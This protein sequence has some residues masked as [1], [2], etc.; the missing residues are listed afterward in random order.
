MSKAK[1]I[2]TVSLHAGN[3]GADGAHEL[4]DTIRCG[5]SGVLP[6]EG[7]SETHLTIGVRNAPAGTQI[8]HAGFWKE[9]RDVDT[10]E[11]ESQ[12]F[13]GSAPLDLSVSG[14]EDVRL[15]ISAS[16]KPE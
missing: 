9:W 13:I 15:V 14:T 5:V 12:E 8:T 7:E 16:L 1:Q 3:P 11:L 4:P 6:I 2:T 10:D